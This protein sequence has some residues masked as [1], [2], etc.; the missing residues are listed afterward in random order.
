MAREQ[1]RD[2]SWTEMRWPSK[3]AHLGTAR[4]TNSQTARRDQETCRHY[5]W[6][7]SD[8]HGYGWP[9]HTDHKSPGPEIPSGIPREVGCGILSDVMCLEQCRYSRYSF[10]PRPALAASCIC[11]AIATHFLGA[12]QQPHQR[13]C[14]WHHLEPVWALGIPDPP[15]RTP[16]RLCGFHHGLEFL[17]GPQPLPQA[18]GID[19]P[20]LKEL[21][22]AGRHASTL[23]PKLIWID[24]VQKQL[25]H[26]GWLSFERV[27]PAFIS[28]GHNKDCVQRFWEILRIYT[29]RKRGRENAQPCQK[30]ITIDMFRRDFEKFFRQSGVRHMFRK[31]S[32]ILTYIIYKIW[33]YIQY[34]YIIYKLII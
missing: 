12:P 32:D 27:S 21:R 24:T 25:G 29:F 34:Q 20:T 4:S 2:S 13:N 26:D 16:L 11:R 28:K 23:S 1:R 30:V 10:G 19:L 17:S 8:T 7:V 9:L 22:R 33:K 3:L 15:H 14:E 18:D 5:S 31:N 6:V